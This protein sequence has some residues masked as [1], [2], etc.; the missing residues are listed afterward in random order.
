MQIEAIRLDAELVAPRP[1]D[2]HVVAERLA[3]LGDVRLQDLRRSGRRTTSPEILDQPVARHGLASVQEQDRQERTW[4]RRVQRDNAPSA[5]ASSGPSTRNSMAHC[6][7]AAPLLYRR[8]TSGAES[9][10]YAASS[11]FSRSQH[12]SSPCRTWLLA[13]TR[14]LGAEHRVRVHG[15]ASGLRCSGPMS[16]GFGSR[17]SERPAVRAGLRAH[18]VLVRR[19][20]PSSELHPA[21]SCECVWGAG[22][23]KLWGRRREPAVGTEAAP[24]AKRS[25]AE[26]KPAP[27]GAEQPTSVEGAMAWNTG[28]SSVPEDRVAPA[29]R[30][31]ARSGGGGNGGDLT[32]H[33]GLRRPRVGEPSDRREGRNADSG[34]RPGSKRFR[35][36]GHRDGRLPRFWRQR[37]RRGSQRWRWRWRWALRRRWRRFQPHLQRRPRRRRLGLRPRRTAFRAGVGAGFG[38]ATISYDRDSRC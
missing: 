36:L 3:E 11:P 6:N 20:L 18:P 9:G 5:T 24:A 19:R 2:D 12:S 25:T 33:D 34:R 26:E 27:A 13:G 23:E 15:I 14:T 38:R 30:S 1:R 16:A 35:S 28:S 32:G 10:S 21:R 37:R 17:S 29:A 8:Y 31:A 4:L 7:G 22:A